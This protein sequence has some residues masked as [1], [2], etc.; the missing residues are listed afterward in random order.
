MKF[1]IKHFVLSTCLFFLSCQTLATSSSINMPYGVTSVSHQIY[2]LHMATF[3][4]CCAIGVVVYTVLFY[5]LFKFR[6]S[7]GAK[8]ANFH[9]NTLVEIIWT[10][11]PFLILVGLAI[12][13]TIV[14]K[15]IHDTEKPT[16]NIKIIGYQWKW[17]Y[18]YLDNGIE[19]FSNL[20]TTQAQINNQSPKNEWFLLEVDNP[21]VVPVNQKIRLLI[22]A[23]DVI[24][25]WWVPELG[26]KQDA[27]PGYINENWVKIDK[28]GIYRGQCGE[29]CGAYHGFMPIVVQAV[30]EPEF[31]TWLAKHNPNIKGS[32]P[33]T[34][35][36]DLSEASLLER[37]KAQ[38]ETTCA[39]CHQISGQGL[40]PT[41]P[42]LKGSKIATGPL[43]NNIDIVLNGK[44]GTAMQAFKDQLDDESLA[45]VMSYIRHA[46]GNDLLNQ[47]QKHEIIVQ[48]KTIA[49]VRNH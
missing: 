45:A 1:T 36:A 7:K 44:S 32:S 43:K 47:S 18:E 27:V 22:T 29:L 49:E 33:K 39:L 4:V 6:R 2:S 31:Q 11:I 19:F 16:L 20:S 10:T 23:N 9:E 14:L 48:P 5:S 37:G 17:K 30:T 28:P 21:M 41:F 25:D 46:W 3:W 13:A 12:P 34:P 38:Y 40:P 35:A 26:I 42:A 8:A 15:N 24:H